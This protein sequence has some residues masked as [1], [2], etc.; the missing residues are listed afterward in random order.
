MQTCL[1]ILY[2]AITLMDFIFN[3]PSMPSTIYWIEVSILMAEYLCF[4]YLA[5]RNF[6]WQ[7]L[8]GMIRQSDV[9][10]LTFC[11]LFVFSLNSNQLKFLSI[12]WIIGMD[13]IRCKDTLF[14]GYVLFLALCDLNAELYE[15]LTHSND[16][17]RQSDY[18]SNYLLQI[19]GKNVHLHSLEIASIGV[20]I[21]RLLLPFYKL[22]PSHYSMS[23]KLLFVRKNR[24]RRDLLRLVRQKHR[25]SKVETLAIGK[26]Q[27]FDQESMSSDDDDSFSHTPS[28]QSAESEKSMDRNYGYSAP[29]VVDLTLMNHADFRRYRFSTTDQVPAASLYYKKR[30]PT[31][32][33][34]IQ[35]LSPRLKYDKRSN[36]NY[37]RIK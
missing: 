9:L 17:R 13:C 20:I 21:I 25:K 34:L 37:T 2:T 18:I 14:L 27:I 29:N 31:D 1:A 32:S 19:E 10:T 7:I 23:K 11:I 4:I 28:V 24:Y 22:R 36:L 5:H 16:D 35:P 33:P 12:L 3:D 15:Q 30:M 26:T 8:Q 6:D